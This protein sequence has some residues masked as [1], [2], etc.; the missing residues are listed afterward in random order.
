MVPTYAGIT[1]TLS[2][3]IANP[4]TDQVNITNLSNLDI[5]IGDYLAIDDEI[6]RV[7]GTVVK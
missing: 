6:V 5:N 1:T 4:T 3:D 7:K 2:A